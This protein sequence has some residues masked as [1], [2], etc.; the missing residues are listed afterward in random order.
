MAKKTGCEHRASSYS[1]MHYLSNPLNSQ[2]IG[3]ACFYTTD[4]DNEALTILEV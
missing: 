4:N 3:A 1:T 2:D